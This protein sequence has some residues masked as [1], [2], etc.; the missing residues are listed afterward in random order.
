MESVGTNCYARAWNKLL[1]EDWGKDLTQ[2]DP[3]PGDLLEIVLHITTPACQLA[4][5]DRARMD[6]RLEVDRY[7]F[8]TAFFSHNCAVPFFIIFCH[9]YDPGHGVMSEE[10]IIEEVRGQNA[11]DTSVASVITVQEARKGLDTFLQWS[12][13]D[14]PLPD[15]I[16]AALGEAKDYVAKYA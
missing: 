1:G 14:E 12:R 7:F 4:G 5:I 6:E 15:H 10:E 8:L 11:A 2:Q 9:R 3:M 13:Q 16:L